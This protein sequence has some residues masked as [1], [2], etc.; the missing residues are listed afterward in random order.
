MKQLTSSAVVV[1]AGAVMAGLAGPAY[2]DSSSDG[3]PAVMNNPEVSQ[4]VMDSLPPII[5]ADPDV[6]IDSSYQ[7]GMPIIFPDGTPVP[8]QAKEQVAAAFF[9]GGAV[10]GPPY[11]WGPTSWRTCSVW[12][13]PGYYRG[14]SWSASYASFTTGCVQGRGF[15]SSGNAQWYSLS[16]GWSGSGA[17]PWGNVLATPATRAT[18][19]GPPAGFTAAW[20]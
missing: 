1:I 5:L 12:G 7:P 19:L 9:C 16:C 6:R 3:S 14:Y 15:N 10:W 18:S 13:H 11:T 4:V 20:N 2:A 8:G 17:V